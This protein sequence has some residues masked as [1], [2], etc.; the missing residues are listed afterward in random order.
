MDTSVRFDLPVP[1]NFLAPP[2]WRHTSRLHAISSVRD[3][4]Q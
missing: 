2:H 1:G 3:I 4:R